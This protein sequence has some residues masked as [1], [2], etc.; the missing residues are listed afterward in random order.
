[1]HQLR[2]SAGAWWAS[3][4]FAL[5]ADHHVPWGKF[6]TSFH[7]HHLSAGLL[8]NKLKEF[9]DL[10]QENHTVFDYMRQF[11]TLSQY[12][13]YHIDTDEKKANLYCAG[14]TIQL[15]DRLVQSLNPSYNDLASAAIDQERTMKAVAEAE[16]KK[17]K[18]V[19]PGSSGS[20]GSSGAPTKYCMVYTPPSGQLC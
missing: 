16:E 1:M 6:H 12:G 15:Q 11:N 4:I 9:L 19:M 20:G 13:S 14:L 7:A 17:R 18:R 2:G 5:P 3:Y 10:E 8:H